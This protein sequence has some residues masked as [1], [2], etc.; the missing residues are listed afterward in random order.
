MLLEAKKSVI[1]L[2]PKSLARRFAV[3]PF[4]G[5]CEHSASADFVELLDTHL[6]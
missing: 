5:A 6:Q 4:Q 2:I 1:E 3:G